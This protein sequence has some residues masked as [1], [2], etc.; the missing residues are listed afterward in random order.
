MNRAALYLRVSREDLAIENQRPELEAMAKRRGLEVVRTYESHVSGASPKRP[1]HERMLKDAHK[2]AFDVLLVWSLDRFGRSMF[3]N[4]RDVMTLDRYGVLIASVKEPWLDTSG[5]VRSLLVAIFS[6]VAQQERERMIE[7]TK[8]GLARARAAG[9]RIGR[10]PRVTPELQAQIEKRVAEDWTIREIAAAL[11]IPK[12]TVYRT[13]RA[14]PR[15]ATGHDSPAAAPSASDVAVHAQAP[16]ASDQ[17]RAA[18]P[19][20]ADDRPSG[21]P[22][23]SGP[24]T[25]DPEAMAHAARPSAADQPTE[26]ADAPSASDKPGMRSTTGGG[27][28]TSQVPEITSSEDPVAGP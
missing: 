4:I 13:V 22:H 10:K 17:R 19:S 7:R 6:W 27:R 2:G 26:H 8:A 12:A 9:K 20:A 14:L 3:E 18:R 11:K 5:P 25:D 23:A 28:A 21:D 1:E 16:S 24:S 15:R